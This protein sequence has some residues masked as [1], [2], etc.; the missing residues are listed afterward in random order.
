MKYCEFQSISFDNFC[1]KMTDD[2]IMR[3][4]CQAFV[5]ERHRRIDEEMGIDIETGAE[6][7]KM[8]DLAPYTVT[9]KGNNIILIESGDMYDEM[10]YQRQNSKNYLI[11]FKSDESARKMTANLYG[12]P[13]EHLPSRNP[14]TFGPKT[15]NQAV[16]LGLI[17]AFTEAMR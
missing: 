16:S 1:K 3:N 8:D 17:A 11:S 10:E 5:D 13:E 4:C 2:L 6:N 12:N 14:W 9:K 7:I 15:D